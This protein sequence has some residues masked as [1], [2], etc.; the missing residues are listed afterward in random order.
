MDSST[1]L[2]LG[3]LPLRHRYIEKERKVLKREWE[4]EKERE[5][6]RGREMEIIER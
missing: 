6:E 1:F 3:V 4:I 2:Q 5:R